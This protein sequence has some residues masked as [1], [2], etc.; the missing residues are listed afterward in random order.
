MN[1]NRSVGVVG[2]VLLIAASFLPY[3]YEEWNNGSLFVFIKDVFSH[4]NDYDYLEAL[5]LQIGPSYGTSGLVIGLLLLSFFL[6]FIGGILALIQYRGG[7]I[8]GL[9]GMLILTFIPLY[10]DG[11]SGI[12]SIGIGFY[13]GWAGAVLCGLTLF[14]AKRRK[15]RKE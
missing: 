4:L 3:G 13:V 12:S 15:S 14:M 5:S 7:S 6:I 9:I 10:R 8:T 11:A 1:T 2:G